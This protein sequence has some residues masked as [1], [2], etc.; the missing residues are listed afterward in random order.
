MITG[1]HQ[2]T[3]LREGIHF[4][5]D[6][7]QETFKMSFPQKIPARV[8]IDFGFL[9]LFFG[10]DYLPGIFGASTKHFL[11]ALQADIYR[12]TSDYILDVSSG[13]ISLTLLQKILQNVKNLIGETPSYIRSNT[14]ASVGQH[15]LELLLWSLN[16]PVRGEL[17]D[18]YQEKRIEMATL[19][20]VLA[21]LE[22]SIK[23]G[24]TTML[25]RGSQG[26]PP[27]PVIYQTLVLFLA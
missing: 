9:L 10:N 19:G 8:A 3:I 2:I 11:N 25:L 4:C 27:V 16:A 14:S 7:V 20:D 17:P 24:Q 5:M 21:F 13:H 12:D 18:V 23:E 15:Y 6:T 22:L 26:T 1:I